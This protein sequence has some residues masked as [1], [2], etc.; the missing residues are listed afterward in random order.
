MILLEYLYKATK[1]NLINLDSLSVL[2]AKNENIIF[3]SKLFNE[4]LLLILVAIV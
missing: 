4:F 1:E 3:E 2:T